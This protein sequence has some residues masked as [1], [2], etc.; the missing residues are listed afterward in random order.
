MT[1]PK[2]I[3][4]VAQTKVEDFMRQP[5]TTRLLKHFLGDGVVTADGADHKVRI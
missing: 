1:Q 4:E 2:L 3:N 5:R